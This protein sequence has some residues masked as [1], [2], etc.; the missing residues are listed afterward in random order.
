MQPCALAPQPRPSVPQ[1]RDGACTAP[2]RRGTLSR[3]DATS[4]ARGDVRR[5]SIERT[6]AITAMTSPG[7]DRPHDG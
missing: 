5:R 2:P 6:T 3:A 1:P 7:A 4:V